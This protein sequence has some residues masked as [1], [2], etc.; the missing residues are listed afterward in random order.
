[1]SE[2]TAALPEVPITTERPL[3]KDL[4]RYVKN[5]GCPRAREAVDREHPDGTIK[6]LHRDM[7]VLQQH[8]AFFDRNGDGKIT[9]IETFLGFRA[10]GFN[11]LISLLAVP[12]IHVN[13]FF[14]TQDSW[15]PNPLCYIYL[16]NIHRAK[17][18]SDSETFDTEGRYVCQKFEEIF[19]KYDRD[20]KGSLTLK[21]LW[22][23][24]EGN[25]NIM[26][27]IGW[28]AGKFEFGVSF[29]LAAEKNAE[30]S[31]IVRKDRLRKIIDGSIF[32]EIEREIKEAKEVGKKKGFLD[33][34]RQGDLA[35]DMK[36]E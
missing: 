30:G 7:S 31:W 1:M 9:P 23:L 6:P 8:C 24:T 10:L 19:S 22:S 36:T 20:N 27:P 2:I 21:E 26:D 5:P 29:L 35:G 34:V 17:H 18:G 16:K 14:P 15:I 32:Y 4:D 12:I 25:R 33:G 28:F 13:F 11:L 3:P